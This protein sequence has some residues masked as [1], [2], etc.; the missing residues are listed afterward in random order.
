M[1]N[2]LNNKLTNVG[3]CTCVIKSTIAMAK[4]VLNKKGAV[5]TSTL[6]LKLRM[7]LVKCD[8][9]DIALYGA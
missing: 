6:D 2:L 1:W 9:W 4:A 8:I 3:R 7:K 5:F